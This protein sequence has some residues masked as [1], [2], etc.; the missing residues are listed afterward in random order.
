ML[1]YLLPDSKE[2]FLSKS[3]ELSSMFI[4]KEH[5]IHFRFKLE[6]GKLPDLNHIRK[7]N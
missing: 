2:D 4:I 6:S 5:L 7:V 1:N 3:I